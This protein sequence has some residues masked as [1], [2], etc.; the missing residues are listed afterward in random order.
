[1]LA[2]TKT[3]TK[4]KPKKPKTIC[5]AFAIKTFGQGANS[6]ASFGV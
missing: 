1:M 4:T 6:R 2:K 3:K 5:D